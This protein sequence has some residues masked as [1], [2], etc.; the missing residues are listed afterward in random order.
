MAIQVEPPKAPEKKPRHKQTQTQ[1]QTQPH[2]ATLPPPQSRRFWPPSDVGVLPTMSSRDKS[3]GP[4]L[5]LTTAAPS[6]QLTPGN[7]SPLRLV[8]SPLT[9]S[10]RSSGGSTP[11]PAHSPVLPPPRRQ[12]PLQQQS[13]LRSPSMPQKPTLMP[14]LQTKLLRPHVRRFS[15]DGSSSTNVSPPSS[16]SPLSP[17]DQPPLNSPMRKGSRVW[18]PAR[19]VELFKRGSEEVLARFLKMGSWEEAPG[20]APER[21]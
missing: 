20:H 12:S 4:E 13:S 10:P 5:S 19:G 8:T 14:M 11:S 2:G 17:P 18:D 6:P 1:T 7:I 15:A 16:V 21:A 3:L 9:R